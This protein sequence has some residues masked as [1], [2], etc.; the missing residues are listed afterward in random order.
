MST[1]Y[2]MRFQSTS[3]YKSGILDM[4]CELAHEHMRYTSSLLKEHQTREYRCCG[5]I[6]ELDVHRA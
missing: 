3:F 2:E 6:A 1:S 5:L 4:A